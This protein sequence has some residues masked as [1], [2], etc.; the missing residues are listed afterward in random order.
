MSKEFKCSV[1]LQVHAKFNMYKR[2]C[3]NCSKELYYANKHNMLR[4]DVEKSQCRQCANIRINTTCS[5]KKEHNSAW[6]G[7]QNVPGKVFSKLKRGAERRNIDFNLTIE[8]I[9]NKYEQQQG[10]CAFTNKTLMFGEDASVDR[11]DSKKGYYYDNIQI[12]HKVLNMLK[13]DMDNEEF[14]M[15]CEQVTNGRK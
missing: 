5:R 13:K 2:L 14:I 12:V 3:G 1:A 4:A 11:I 15:W 8:D 10:L 7:Y 9:F 6:K